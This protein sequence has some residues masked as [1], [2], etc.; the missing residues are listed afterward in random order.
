MVVTRSLQ[1]TAKKSTRS[2]RT[3][4]CQL[5][6][7]KNGEKTTISSR[8][9][10]LDQ[11]MPQYLGV[12]K[13][14][15]DS[16]IFCHQDE[17]L[18][19]MSEPSVL[20]KKFDEIFEA[21]KYTKA[22]DNIKQ[23][24]KKQIEELGKYKIMEQHAKEGKDKA[25]RVCIDIYHNFMS[26]TKIM[27][28]QA[29]RKSQELSDEIEQL[30]IDTKE[31]NRKSNDAANKSQEAWSHSA[32]YEHVVE[33]LKLNREKEE[34]LQNNLE[35]LG[36]GLTKSPESDEWLKTEFSQY[37][38]R[39]GIY[40]ERK[41]NQAS[42]Y[43]TLRLTIEKVRERL[44]SKHIEAGKF[45][46]QKANYEQQIE[47]RAALIRETA[48]YHNLRAYENHLEDPQIAEY[49][50]KISKLH[51][52]QVNAVE[53]VRRET[54]RERQ[55]VQDVLTKLGE[56]KW[57][58]QESQNFT[59]EK[60]TS[61]DRKMNSLQSE[62]NDI[63]IDEGGRAVIEAN[64]DDLQDRLTRSKEE[65]KAA[66][67]DT[68]LQES[69]SQVRLMED[70]SEKLNQ[71]L[72]QATMQAGDLAK[73]DHLEHELKNAQRSFD[74]MIGAHSERLRSILGPNWH[75][76]TLEIDFQQVV[77]QRAKRVKDTERERDN[78]S[79]ILERADY[80]LKSLRAN[81]KKGEEDISNSAEIIRRS[82]QGEPA[83]YLEDLEE[84]QT[85]RD[86]LKADL[87][88]YVN[89][90]KF[91]SDSV[92]Y[93]EKHQK[94]KLCM[95]QF[96]GNPDRQKFIDEMEKKIAKNAID[97]LQKQL[98]D[99]ESE[100]AAA[101]EARSSYDVWLRLSRTDLPK[102]KKEVK[103]CEEGQVT[104]VK[105]VERYDS[106]VADRV[107]AK[108]DAETLSRP[109][110]NIA[111]Y[112]NDVQS[113]KD[114]IQELE[115]KKSTIG[116]SR[117]LQ[118]IQEELKATGAKS[119]AAR[120]SSSN[121]LIEKER[122]RSQFTSLELELSKAKNSLA[123][124]NHHLGKKAQILTQIA[125]LKKNNSENQVTLKQL[126]AQIQGMIPQIAEEQTKLEDKKQRGARKEK[127]MQQQA[128]E[129]LDSVHRL[130]LADHNIQ[131]YIREG[132]STKLANCQA[133]IESAQ[134]EVGLIENEQ[135]QIVVE[136]NKID[137]QLRNHQETKRTI[138]DNMKYRQTQK[139][140]ASV[141]AEI[142]TLSAQNAEADLEHYKRQATHWQ[143]QHRLHSTA[144][145]SKMA[146]M[147]AKDDQLMQLLDE[148][149]TDYKD[150]AFKYK[151]SHIK[152]EVK[153]D[154]FRNPVVYMSMLTGDRPPRQQSK[155]LRITEAHWIS[156][157]S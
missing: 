17:S 12:S 49:L 23:L 7:S 56:R 22:I 9:A 24:R 61:N 98:T 77:E 13:A 144:E 19:P 123:D 68:K 119:R 139:D 103:E 128:T 26:P 101:K 111:K 142:A 120:E 71:E 73:L 147:K 110:A 143:N 137:A 105:E 43:E 84:L 145:T 5:L 121:L 6:M 38:Q 8:L 37:E 65:F 80:Q 57:G 116:M 134:K 66:C 125:D 64:I 130:N 29:E 102:L 42:R 60:S 109:V 11:I 30:R 54:E 124:A 154:F 69:H 70:E 149:N 32:K 47:R 75:P 62:L 88:N 155:I 53:Q 122:G 90:R 14:I 18:W 27:I 79:R 50:E 16:V 117:T 157:S 72:I 151:E 100:L 107:E 127:E 91:Y 35:D 97:D 156:K 33:S 2:L 78:V 67:W 112:S 108:R 113:L 83:D 96:Q 118:E 48:R 153:F 95:R 106:L 20:K 44:Q 140:L 126:D 55:K 1:L 148:W 99:T 93:V 15:L 85:N 51:R 31:L 141:K 4:E 129:L 136:I 41:Q 76:S 94:C 135:K 86:T 114:Q 36:Q 133:D 152:V 3:L 74:T 45:E 104:S 40:E 25:E 21:L 52:D 150:A 59:R 28:L 82:T 39:M 138:Y 131:T 63:K 87:D 146:T 92:R 46:E 10:E 58:L 89:L 115:A 34:W 81:L 132:G